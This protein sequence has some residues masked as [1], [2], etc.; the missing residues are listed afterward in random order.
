MDI[1]FQDFENAIKGKN[2]IRF[3]P[4]YQEEF[5]IKI[6]PRI[7]VEIAAKTIESL[8]WEIVFQDDNQIE[9]RRK[10][11]FDRWTNKIIAIA[12]NLGKVVIKSESLGNEMCDWGRNSKR[13]KLFIY[14]FNETL[15]DYDDAKLAELEN[16]VVKKDNW[17]DYEIPETLPAPKKYR[18][19]QILIPLIGIG[20]VSLALAYLIALLSLEGLYV[21]FLFEVG[22][23]IILGFSFKLLMKLGNFTDWSKIRLILIGAVIHTFIMNQV[24]Q[25][26]LILTRNNYE[27]IGFLEFIKLRLEQGLTVKE[28]N[29]G[30]IGLIISWI[31]QL[32]LTYLI[33]YLRTFSAIIKICIQRVPVEVF[34]FAIYHFVKGKNE[35]AVKQELSKMGW[36]SDLE[37]EMVFE[38]IEGAQGVQIL[39]RA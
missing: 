36:K 34:D 19:P 16:E 5:S 2:S 11:D 22:V 24:F 14:A 13:V 3:T 20:A 32:G 18:Q 28:L 17:D 10:S 31:I 29:V 35:I 7:F 15:K 37:H 4:K 9:A 23:G 12:D 30:S 8:D 25:Y 21:I 6:K 33:G 26:Q 1:K 27:P 38:A 39:N